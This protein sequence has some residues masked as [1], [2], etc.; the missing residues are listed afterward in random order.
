M[1]VTVLVVRRARIFA[2]SAG[3]DLE[4]EV[5]AVEV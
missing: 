5:G 4:Q 3:S 2:R 1:P